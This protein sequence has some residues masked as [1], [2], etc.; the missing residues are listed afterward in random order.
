VSAPTP[1]VKREDLKI[2][3]VGGNKLEVTIDHKEQGSPAAGV[4]EQKEGE[5]DENRVSFVRKGFM[6]L[7]LPKDADTSQARVEYADGLLRVLLPSSTP[8]DTEKRMR[9]ADSTHADLA[10]DYNARCEKVKELREQLEKEMKEA[11]Q[12]QEKLREARYK[13]AQRIASERR[14][15]TF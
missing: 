10:N 13:E 14:A 11:A 1:G 15:L 3:I 5:K 6:S 8:E 9:I 2:E 12:A 7:T 4:D